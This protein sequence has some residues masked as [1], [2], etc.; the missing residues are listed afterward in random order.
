V[1]VFTVVSG[2]RLLSRVAL[3]ECI[4]RDRRL[5]PGVPVR[6]LARRYGVHR[7]TVRQA[8]DAA[9]PPERVKPVVGRRSVLGPATVWIDEMLRADV[10]APRKQRHTIVRIFERLREEH[11]F[12]EVAYTT[13][14]NYVN[15]RRPQINAEAR[16]GHRHVEGMV[17]QVHEPGAEAEVDFAD[18][19]VRLAGEPRK[20]HLFTLRMSY[21]GKAVHRVFA[22]QAQEAFMQGHVEAF[23]VLGGV[24][25]RHIRYDNLRPAVNQVCFGRN[26]VESQ[27]WV[28]FRSHYGFDAFYCIPGI[29]GAHEKGGV[30]HEGGRFR[31]NHLVPVPSLN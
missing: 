4:R 11:G 31:R 15:R 8:L 13:V 16:E 10:S 14:R 28:A 17:P 12:D 26:R 25:T 21:S 2:V 23:A 29:G 24:P 9:V 5:E 27:R 22:S 20:C 3:F 19:W 6:E 18:V 7:R 30:E 1:A